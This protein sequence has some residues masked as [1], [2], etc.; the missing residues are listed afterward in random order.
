MPKSWLVIYFP[1][2]DSL[3]ISRPM[4]VGLSTIH[5]S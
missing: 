2:Y 4:Q 3:Q 1:T 5:L